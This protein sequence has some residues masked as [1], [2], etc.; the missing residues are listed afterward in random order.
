LPRGKPKKDQSD[1]TI[2]T[3]TKTP[4]IEFA[5]LNLKEIYGNTIV[6]FE[7][8]FRPNGDLKGFNLQT[9]LRDVQ[10]NIYKVYEL[11]AYYVHSDDIFS[12]AI[13]NVLVPFSITPF[14]L[15]GSS[16]KAKDFF[17]NYFEEIALNDLLF[18]IYY[19]L[20]LYGNCFLYRHQ[21]G[22]VQVLPP[23]RIEIQDIKMPNEPVLAYRIPESKS[24]GMSQVSE[25]FIKTMEAKYGNNSYPPE[26]LEGIKKG[27]KV[28][29]LDPTRT[30]AIQGAKSFWEK[31]SL[32]LGT[33]L[34]P[35]FSKKNLIIEAEKNELVN[36]SKS[37]LHVRVGDKD[38][39]AKPNRQELI[40]VANS[41]IS[42]LSG[43]N[44]AVTSWDIAADWR[45]ISSKDAGNSIRA[46]QSEV[47]AA[48][49]SGLGLA[50]V[51]VTGDASGSSFAA[52]QVNT[53][54]ASKRLNQ[55]IL[56][57]QQFLRKLMKVVAIEQ[58]IADARIPDIIFE[59]VDLQTK[60]EAVAEILKL[61]EK[62]LVGY[63][64]VLETAK[65]DY[66]QERDRK[67]QEKKDGDDEIFLPPQ[68]P[69]NQTGDPGEPGN[70]GLDDKS[71]TSDKSKS[72]SGKNPKPSN[73]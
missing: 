26:I 70:P 34:L 28:V 40:D 18:G 3:E 36:L 53:A 63:R 7:T 1:Q 5:A 65:L 60:S 54:V 51:I 45:Y 17:A 68:N 39:R 69:F 64:T 44:L 37:V 19:D 13:Q 27:Q 10:T 33:C 6:P 41:F 49:L 23:H 30:Y 61:F 71:R 48:I 25:T 22:Y 21:N 9:I 15:Q 20:Y 14:R 38:K 73:S 16:Q 57:V 24:I 11:M 8:Q 67:E 47:N 62:G 35:L 56:N 55:N 52:A 31:F 42:A 66:Q 59:P 29:Q 72:A 46:K 2:N 32:P 50:S 4:D 43:Y 58:R 12:S